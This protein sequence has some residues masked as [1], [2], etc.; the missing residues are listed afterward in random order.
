MRSCSIVTVSDPEDSVVAPLGSADAFLITRVSGRLPVRFDARL[1][2]TRAIDDEVCAPHF[3]DARVG[4]A[5]ELAQVI[6][7]I[8]GPVGSQDFS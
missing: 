4:A 5:L 8:D 7:Q 3:L 1:A 2:S 6:E